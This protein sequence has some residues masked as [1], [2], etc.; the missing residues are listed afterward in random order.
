MKNLL[1]YI[2]IV[3]VISACSENTE[4]K[5]DAFVYEE[6]TTQNSQVDIIE[7]LDTLLQKDP[8]NIDVLIRLAKACKKEMNFA[9]SFNASA[10][11]YRLDTTNIEARKIYVWSL[12]N[13]YE[14]KA[15]NILLARKHFKYILKSEPQNPEVYVNLANTYTL[16]GDFKNSFNYLNEALKLDKQYKDAYILKGSNYRLMDKKDLATSSFETAL[17]LDQTDVDAYLN[18]ADYYVEIGNPIA[19]EYYQTALELNPTKKYFKLRA[20][21]GI[22]KTNQDLGKTQD[23]LA[24]YRSL[25][26]VDS[27]FYQAYFNQAYIKQFIQKEMDSAIYF[28]NETLELQPEYI[29][30][31]HNLGLAYYSEERSSDAARAFSNALKIDETY[32]PSK[33]AAEKLLKR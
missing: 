2:L 15:E 31:W 27:N 11:A 26:E 6:D 25:L 24:G 1:Q 30:A 17:Q 13:Q 7:E 29:E 28:Y 21:Y 20:L 14:P 23:A 8:N 12:I 16:T 5:S 33:E 3:F 22:A 4:V 9:C 32:A 10:K 19:L 18:V